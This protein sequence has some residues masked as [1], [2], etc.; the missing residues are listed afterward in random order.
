MR[1]SGLWSLAVLLAGMTLSLWSF[2]GAWR[3]AKRHVS[4]GGLPLWGRVARLT[5][6][7]E[8]LLLVVTGSEQ[9]S[10]LKQSVM[11]ALGRDTMPAAN[12][13]IV[14]RATEVE[15]SGGLSFG[16]ADRLKAILDVTPT[17]R[18]VRLDS[19]GGWIAEGAKLA[20]LIE[21]RRLTTRTSSE[22]DS[23][24][25][26]VFMAGEH[27]FLGPKANLGF[28]Q[29]SVAGVGGEL[30][31]EGTRTIR[32]ALERRGV[33]ETLSARHY[34]S[35]HRVSGIRRPKSLSLRM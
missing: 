27:R 8:L 18:S 1:A 25:L 13:R 30:A 24:C 32:E 12:L 19:K 16:A 3:S 26:L 14:N 9:A 17:I 35:R 11:L 22:C 31:S 6:A 28:H 29:A 33:R 7:L 23:A 21:R 15:I 5:L 20:D 2:V 4:R 10:I 34:P